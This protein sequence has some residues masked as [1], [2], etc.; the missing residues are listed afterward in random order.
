M[1]ISKIINKRTLFAIIG[2]LILSISV[3]AYVSL[4]KS[5]SIEISFFQTIKSLPYISWTAINEKDTAKTGVT[6]YDP[7]LSYKGINL[8]G[9][10]GKPC[11]YV[12]DMSGN[13]LHTFKLDD[14]EESKWKIIE[15]YQNDYFLVLNPEVELLMINWDSDVKWRK[16]MSAHHDIAVSDNGEIY[17]IINK[18]IYLPQF[19]LTKLFDDD[20]LVVLTKD[21]KIKKEI[22]F[23]KMILSNKRFVNAARKMTPFYINTVE[24]ID[25]D[26]FFGARRLFK[27]G[28]VLFCVRNLNIIGVAD[29]EKEKFIWGWGAGNLDSPHSPSLLEN[30]NILIFDNGVHRGHSRIIEVNPGTETIEWE[31]KASPPESFFSK[32]RGAVQWLPNGNIL[33]TESDKGRVFEVTRDKKIVWEFYN[34]KIEMDKRATI[35]RMIRVTDPERCTRLQELK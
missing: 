22:S 26:V 32:S 31:Y 35:W 8:Y 1:D 17:T 28:D 34:P 16:K 4:K 21:G 30:G 2:V 5:E 12:L 7:K 10:E 33:I 25:R 27:K 11:A 23:G 14:E 3:V 18:K 13:I 20:R 24:I 6:K 15:P 29:I 9:G 19:H